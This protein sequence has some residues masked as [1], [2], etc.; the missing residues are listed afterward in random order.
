MNN[1][2]LR[3]DASRPLG[4]LWAHVH[5]LTV[6]GEAGSYT[7]DRSNRVWLNLPPARVWVYRR[8]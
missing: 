2:P 3:A 7:A 4:S 8:P 5:A 6:L 1:E